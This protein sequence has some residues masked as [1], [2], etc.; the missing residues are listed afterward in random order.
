M[1][2][3]SISAND[4]VDE[5]HSY[6]S[7]TNPGYRIKTIRDKII[8]T[9]RKAELDTCSQYVGN[10]IAYYLC[11]VVEP[12]VLYSMLGLSNITDGQ[13][14][15]NELR[16]AS[17]L[18]EYYETLGLQ[19]GAMLRD[20]PTLNLDGIIYFRLHDRLRDLYTQREELLTTYFATEYHN[21]ETLNIIYRQGHYVISNLVGEVF[22]AEEVELLWQHARQTY[23]DRNITLEDVVAG[24]ILTLAPKK[25]I[26][27]G[28]LSNL[29]GTM[30]AHILDCTVTS[31]PGCN[32][33][34]NLT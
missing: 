11:D 3:I 27:H 29:L 32:R 7:T 2:T 24:V 31:C 26:L 15:I 13:I 23:H 5:L 4:Q 16:R 14:I 33:C 8:L 20:V 6:L 17:R 19:L 28:M 10:K 21:G 1:A 18:E 12:R 25:L 30:L 22:P 9:C 34:S